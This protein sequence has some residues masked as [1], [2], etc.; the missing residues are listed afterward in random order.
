[1][2]TY[3]CLF[4]IFLIHGSTALKTKSTTSLQGQNQN[5]SLEEQLEQLYQKFKSNIEAKQILKDKIVLF[6]LTALSYAF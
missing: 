6:L 1:M 4:V 2:K 3:L 5:S